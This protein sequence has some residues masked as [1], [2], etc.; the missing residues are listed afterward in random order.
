MMLVTEQS[1][2]LDTATPAIDSTLMTVRKPLFVARTWRAPTNDTKLRRS[3]ASRIERQERR[4]EEEE[5]DD[6]RRER[7]EP[8]RPRA[9]LNGAQRDGLERNVVEDLRRDVPRMRE[10]CGAEAEAHQRAED[11]T[12]SRRPTRLSFTRP[13]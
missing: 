6:A 1:A 7:G 4:E 8:E 5:E 10:S 12:L 13:G 11:L 9:T 3:S 2:Q